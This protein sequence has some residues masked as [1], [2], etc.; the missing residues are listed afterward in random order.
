MSDSEDPVDLHDDG[1]DDLFGDDDDLAGSPLP[2]VLSDKDLDSDAEQA[3]DAGG[4]DSDRDLD[5][6]RHEDKVI[7]GI[8][9]YRHRTPKTKNG[10][11]ASLK[12]PDFIK[13]V[14]EPFDPDNFVPTAWDIENA[15]SDN[16]KPVVRWYRDRDSGE[17]RSNANIFKWS[18]GSLSMSVGDEHFVIQKKELAPQPGKPYN[19]LQDTHTYAAAAHLSS[20]LFMIVGH[21]GEEYTIRQNKSLED[22]ALQRLAMRMRAAKAEDEASRI[23]KTTHDPEL[24]RKQA[25]I[26]EKERMKVQ[27]RRENA[28]ARMDG[29]R[30]GRG[31]GLL[32]IDEL[33]GGR[34]SGG[35]KRGA[36]GGKSKKRRPEYDSDD[37]APEGARRGEDYDLEDDFIAPSDEDEGEGEDDEEELLDDDDDDDDKPRSK[38]QKTKEISDD[39]DADGEEDEE[40][41]AEY[42]GRRR[43]N[44]IDDDDD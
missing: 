19:E 29:P 3:N 36:P 43:R 37:D 15:R 41:R 4:Y 33:E 12:V 11:L 7:A 22:D 28:A 20:G 17:L 42:S 30:S 18:D 34:R 9:I 23:I 6:P 8:Q 39:E 38:R 14:P 16:P 44:I 10:M 40:A 25:E 24:Q 5:A 31:G 27:R 35:R 26:A 2:Q 13:F 1:G 32:S 21:V